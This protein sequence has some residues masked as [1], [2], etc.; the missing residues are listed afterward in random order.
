MTNMLV[1][2]SKEEPRELQVPFYYFQ[3]DQSGVDVVSDRIPS[4]SHDFNDGGFRGH[5]SEG[6]K[7]SIR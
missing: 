7:C 5:D 4:E 3:I 6:K 2:K 1:R